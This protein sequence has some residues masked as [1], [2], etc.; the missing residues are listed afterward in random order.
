MQQPATS[1]EKLIRL[2]RQF[3]ARPG[4]CLGNAVDVQNAESFLGGIIVCVQVFTGPF[5]I[6]ELNAVIASRGWRVSDRPLP[7]PEES[8]EHQMRQRGMSDRQIIAELAE[9]QA[10]TLERRL[11]SAT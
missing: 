7:P 6:E 10:L 5:S 1:I 8:L 9:I 3:G 11:T 2:V 4:M